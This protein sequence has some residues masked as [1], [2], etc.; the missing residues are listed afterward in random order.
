MPEANHEK[1]LAMHQEE[2]T[3][4]TGLLLEMSK[5]GGMR[6]LVFAF[7]D[8]E[9]QSGFGFIAM[10]REEVISLLGALSTLS[11]MMNE[12]IS[13][14]PGKKGAWIGTPTSVAESIAKHTAKVLGS[15]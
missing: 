6:S 12:S 8:V 5:A 1:E 10:G 13:D 2:L 11:H 15:H 14:D 9:C 4:A 3:K 7:R